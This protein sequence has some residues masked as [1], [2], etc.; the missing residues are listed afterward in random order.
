MP[1]A[2]YMLLGAVCMTVQDRIPFLPY[3]LALCEKLRCLLLIDAAGAQSPFAAR[4]PRFAVL[5]V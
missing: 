2:K 3:G 4:L 1:H 5:V